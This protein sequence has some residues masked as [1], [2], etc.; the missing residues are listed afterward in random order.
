MDI[1]DV[2]CGLF[3]TGEL[4]RHSSFPKD[5][6]P[7]IVTTAK[8]L[9]NGFPI[10]AILVK[11]HVAEA[12]SIGSHG[13][14]FGGQPLAARMGHYVFSRLSEPS[15]IQS[16]NDTAAHLDGLIRRL[17]E[18]FPD[19]IASESRGKGLIR[20]IPFKDEKAPAELTRLARERGLLLLTAGKDAVRLV[21]AL[22]V[23]KEQ[24]DK[25][26]AIMESCLSIMQEKA[27]RRST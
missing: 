11:D 5:A 25:A 13:T 16:I 20:G 4:W 26:V 12:I 6:Q 24:C 9:A 8:A 18:M 23:S 7:D 19:L 3:R 17:A 1:A 14:T 2:Q 27:G 15:F 22:I 10:G 21:P